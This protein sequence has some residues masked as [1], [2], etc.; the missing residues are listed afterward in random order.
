MSKPSCDRR[1]S[2]VLEADP[3]PKENLLKE[4][5]VFDEIQPTSSPCRTRRKLARQKRLCHADLA[6]AAS[7]CFLSLRRNL[8]TSTPAKNW[9]GCTCGPACIQRRPRRQPRRRERRRTWSGAWSSTRTAGRSRPRGS[10]PLKDLMEPEQV[11]VV[12]AELLADAA[13]ATG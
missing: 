3:Q 1:L 4:E 6:D 5:D 11:E 10:P 8:A 13:S 2:A 7:K 12:L 9:S